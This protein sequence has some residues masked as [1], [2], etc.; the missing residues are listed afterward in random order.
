MMTMVGPRMMS[1]TKVPV[2]PETPLAPLALSEELYYLLRGGVRG[3][4]LVLVTVAT[5]ERG[6]YGIYNVQ[7]GAG[8]AREFYRAVRR[9]GAAQPQPLGLCFEA[10][11]PAGSSGPSEPSHHQPATPPRTS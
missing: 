4:W 11:R 8:G 3:G 9:A 1:F 2:R 10:G 7:V 6:E 5:S